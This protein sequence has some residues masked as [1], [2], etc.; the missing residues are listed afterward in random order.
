MQRLL[1][2]ILAGGTGERLSILSQARAKPAVPF[3]GK[4]RIIDFSL[5]NCVN[6]EIHNVI[7]LTQYQPVSLT[8]HIGIGAPWGLVPPDRNIRLLQPYL[9]RD[10]GR[11]WYK[12]TADAVYQNLDRIEA[13]DIEE[14]LV[15]SGDHVYKMDYSMMLEFHREAGADVTMAVI[16]MPEEDLARFGTVATD[17]RWAV[18]RF[19]EKVKNPESNLVS[20]GVYI[21]NKNILRDWLEGRTGHDFGRNIF[22]KMAINGRVF[23]YLFE[24]Y[25]RDIGTVESYWQSNMD[26][27]EMSRPFLSDEDWPLYTK[28]TE[29]PPAKICRTAQVNNC[30]L[31]EGCLIEGHVE[32]SILSPWVRVSEGAVVKDSI[33][34]DGTEVGRGCIIDRSILDKGITVG[35]NCHIGF[36]DDYRVNRANPKMLNTGLTIIGKRSAIPPCYRI[37]RNCII[38]DNVAEDDFS[39]SEVPSGETVKPRRKPIRIKA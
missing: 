19:R 29:Y 28:E 37:G 17:E 3:A 36:G 13:E 2:V 24:G 16:R 6:S 10:E 27:L 9:A 32:R 35:D 26:V 39:G 18:T 34:M 20:M 4:Y 31:S 21:F 33:I 23:A 8:E 14:V 22:P 25:W 7:V 30:L 1:A 38:Y 15:L 11:D 5:S 12:G